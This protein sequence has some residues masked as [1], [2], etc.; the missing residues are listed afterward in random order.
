M[1]MDVV[2]VMVEMVEVEMNSD[3]YREPLKRNAWVL[4]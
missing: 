3:Y 2:E 1:M 4:P